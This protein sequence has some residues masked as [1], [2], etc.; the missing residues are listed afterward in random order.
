MVTLPLLHVQYFEYFFAF[1][2]VFLFHV[3]FG[4]F[5]GLSFLIFSRVDQT[6]RSNLSISNVLCQYFLPFFMFILA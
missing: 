1:W 5:K 3:V 4:V 2:D 6:T